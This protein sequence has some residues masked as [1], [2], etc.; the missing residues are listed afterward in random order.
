MLPCRRAG[1]G[2]EQ[3]LLLQLLRLY[4]RDHDRSSAALPVVDQPMT[5]LSLP[6]RTLASIRLPAAL[7]GM[8]LAA[9]TAHAECAWVLWTQ[10][11]RLSDGYAKVT[12]EGLA[13]NDAYKSKA[14]CD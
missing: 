4:R 12:D 8:L 7:L 11:Y 13:P 5:H 10:Q 3:D 1:V 6:W 2:P 9:I 14:E